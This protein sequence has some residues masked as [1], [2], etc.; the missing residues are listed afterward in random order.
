Q[1]LIEACN[2]SSWLESEPNISMTVLFD[3][4]EVGSL[5][6]HGA[7]STML[8]RAIT[9]LTNSPNEAGLDMAL[10]RSMHVSA[11]MAHAV[12][13]NYS[14]KH[15]DNMKPQLHM[16]PVVKINCNTRYAT[17]AVTNAMLHTLAHKNDIPIQELAVRNDSSCGTTIGPICSANTGIRTVDIGNPQLSMHSIREMCGTTDIKHCV[18]LMKVFFTQWTALEDGW[19]IDHS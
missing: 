11:D 18:D 13:P 8:I 17:T 9:R 16:G 5:S 6:A 3:N 1:S 19:D 2:D 12:H 4:E 14:E 10:A 7:Q 15:E